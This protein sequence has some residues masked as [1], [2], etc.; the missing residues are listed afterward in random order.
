MK[1][2]LLKHVFVI[3]V[4][5]LMIGANSILAQ[6]SSESVEAEFDVMTWNIQDI[7]AQLDEAQEI[8]IRNFVSFIYPDVLGL[9]EDFERNLWDRIGITGKYFYNIMPSLIPAGWDIPCIKIYGN[10]LATF[11]NLPLGYQDTQNIW[12]GCSGCLMDDEFLFDCHAAKGFTFAH[13]FAPPLDNRNYKIHFYNLHTDAGNNIND[14]LARN[15]QLNVQLNDFMNTNSAGKAVI[16]VGDFNL[17]QGTLDDTILEGFMAAQGLQMSCPLSQKT[18]DD[19][20]NKL[21]FILYRSGN[22]VKLTKLDCRVHY[23]WNGVD[24]STYCDHYPVHADFH[25]E[26][27]CGPL[28]DLQVTN[29][30]YETTN[31]DESPKI[32]YVTITNTGPGATAEHENV[33]TDVW[34]EDYHLG[35]FRVE[36]L[37]GYPIPLGSGETY[38]GEMR[39]PDDPEIMATLNNIS[40]TNE[41]QTCDLVK[42]HINRE[43]YVPELYRENNILEKY[44]PS[45]YVKL[46]YPVGGE[47]L[48]IGKPVTIEWTYSGIRRDIKIILLKGGSPVGEIATCPRANLSYTWTVTDFDN[49][50]GS[51]YKIK[52]IT[53]DE[54]YYDTSANFTIANEVIP[55]ITVTSPNGGENWE[56]GSSK[57][58]TWETTAIT[59][60]VKIVLWKDGSG[61]GAID[62]NLNPASGSYTWT[63]GNLLNGTTV[64][65]GSGYKIRIRELVPDG[66]G[67]YDESN[68]PFNITAPEEPDPEMA[69]VNMNPAAFDHTVEKGTIITDTFYVKNIGGGTLNFTVGDNSSWITVS[70]TSGS[71]TSGQRKKITVT[72][73]T[74]NLAYDSHNT[75]IV[76]VNGQ[77]QD[78]GII[79]KVYIKPKAPDPDIDPKIDIINMNPQTFDHTVEKGTTLTDTFYVRNI[80]GGTLNFTVGDN[81]SWISVSPTS[82]SCTSGQSKQITATITT[83]GLSYGSYNTGT[84][85]VSAPDADNSPQ[86][87]SV[88]VRI[89]HQRSSLYRYFNASIG[90][91]F[92]TTNWNELGNG[93]GGYVYEGVACYVFKQQTPG[94]VKLYRYLNNSIGDHYYT[95]NWNEL[96]SGAGGYVYEGVACYVYKSQQPGT[97][98]LYRYLNSSIGDHYYTTN[99][100]ELGNGAGG[101]VYEGIACYVH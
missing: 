18:N 29:L 59:G 75:G 49:G 20:D 10:G 74:S 84:I 38:I 19:R 21:D 7:W 32:V 82:G 45:R 40:S 36:D 94:L 44:L 52:I 43:N 17:H 22:K 70:P 95:T 76:N 53:T 26:T 81:S 65:A 77:N 16:I 9:Q 3:L 86:T 4:I 1:K 33:T 90:D 11:T 85:T 96:G 25:V 46:E 92:Y 12:E 83:D 69:I 34:V 31:S 27:L 41:G 62:R 73:K 30:E 58:I 88:S 100:N 89:R 78:M 97:K 71:C 35:S 42:A 87:I 101:Y 99:W 56:L 79:V 60:D 63:V 55:T 14:L 51:D 91:H 47:E 37:N 15:D 66:N 6:D 68:A 8:G 48:I 72:I 93:A 64:A 5:C 67:P 98:K 23:D 50:S 57:T 24:L 2:K 54:W 80:G 39:F 61:I 13:L 28:P